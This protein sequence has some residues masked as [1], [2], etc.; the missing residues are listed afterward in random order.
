MLSPAPFLAAAASPPTDG[1]AGW[2]VSIME[3]L[4]APGVAVL[5]ALENIFPP[6]PSEVFLPLAGFT[7][8]VGSMSLT[9]AIV[10]ATVGSLVGAWALYWLGVVLGRDRLIHIIDKMPMVDV[11]DMVKA[12][13]V[14]NRHGRSAVFFGRLMPIVRSLISIPAGLERMPFVQFSIF[15]FLGSL[16]WNAALICAGYWLGDQYDVVQNYV[17]YFQW[18]IVAVI[19]VVVVWYVVKLVRRHRGKGD[20]TDRDTS[21]H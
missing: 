4:G 15:T 13:S 11:D 16:V 1:I 20:D 7:A 8:G 3:A 9:A 10:W 18:V 19:V 12:E 14:F 17:G 6:I 21:S 2:A 5:V